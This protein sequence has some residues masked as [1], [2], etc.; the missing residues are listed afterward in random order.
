MVLREHVSLFEQGKIYQNA[1]GV[2]LAPTLEVA[3]KIIMIAPTWGNFWGSFGT[4]SNFWA[5]QD[6]TKWLDEE[7]KIQ[8]K[9]IP[10]YT[11][12]I[13][14]DKHGDFFIKVFC[15]FGIG[16]TVLSHQLKWE[17]VR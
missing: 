9:A 8:V 16:W 1:S 15:E 14:L 5:V 10:E 12:C 7:H 6:D 11:N 3:K 13:Y 2:I 4:H 17:I